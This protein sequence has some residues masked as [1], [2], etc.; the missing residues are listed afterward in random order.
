MNSRLSQMKTK[1]GDLSRLQYHDDANDDRLLS[2]EKKQF[3]Y[4]DQNFFT[5]PRNFDWVILIH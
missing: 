4:S 1:N 5:D 2:I 3:I